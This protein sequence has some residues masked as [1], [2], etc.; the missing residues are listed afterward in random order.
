M[1]SQST[2]GKILCWKDDPL[3]SSLLITD[4]TEIVTTS[5]QLFHHVLSYMMDRQS[6]HSQ[7]DHAI[8]IMNIL[9]RECN[10][11]DTLTVNL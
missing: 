2:I 7:T 8:A 9:Y 4:N 10:I 1:R 6:S 11:N 3:E 5:I